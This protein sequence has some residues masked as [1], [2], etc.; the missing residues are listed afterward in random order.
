MGKREP[1]A[2]KDRERQ[3]QT[4]SKVAKWPRQRRLGREERETVWLAPGVLKTQK[5]QGLQQPPPPVP[6]QKAH[7]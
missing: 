1:K 7:A 5:V 4:G 6:G 3:R 2:K